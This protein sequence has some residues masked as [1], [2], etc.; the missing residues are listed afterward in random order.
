VPL[1]LLQLS[2]GKETLL[3]QRLFLYYSFAGTGAIAVTIAW[4]IL[5][6]LAR[7]TAA[8]IDEL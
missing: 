8:E 1:P 2:S 5:P 7:R 3:T 6:E 4:F